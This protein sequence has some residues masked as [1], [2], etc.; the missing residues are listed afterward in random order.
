MGAV[1][2]L[3]LARVINRYDF[4]DTIVR[5]LPRERFAVEVATFDPKANIQEPHYEALGIPHHLIPVQAMQAY[6]QYLRAAFRLAA[7]IKKRNISILHT[8]HFWEGVVGALAKQLYPSFKFIAHRH[9]M[10]D[11]VR[12]G[13]WKSYLLAKL[14]AF[15]YKSADAIV[16]STPTVAHFVR[17]QYAH[18]SSL[19]LYEI[20]YG[21]ELEAPKYQPVS[22]Q[23][24]SKLRQH[25]GAQEGEIIIT[26]IGT[27]RLQKGQREL[28]RAFARLSA[29]LPQVRLWLVGT[30]PDTALLQQLAQPLGDRVRFWG[31]QP[32]ERVREFIGASDIIAHPTYSENFPQIMIEALSLERALI[33]SRVSGANDMLTHK[34]NAWLIS[35]Q[36]EEELYTGL[37]QLSTESDLRLSLGQAGRKLLEEYPIHY[38]KINPHYEALYTRL[39]SL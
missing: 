6:P 30:G 15:T 23:E 17:K 24:R 36:N 14:E 5:Y 37:Y 13:G 32:G 38:T 26:N 7:L 9:Y 16:V 29:Q 35:P 31:W 25:Y 1:R 27:H 4:I 8:H 11:V 39:C 21:F 33:I 19:P 20:P 18:Q 34:V 10:E 2:V 12:V 22:P 3:Q 28:I